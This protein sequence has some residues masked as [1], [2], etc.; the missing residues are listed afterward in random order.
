MKVK[1]CN[2]NEKTGFDGDRIFWKIYLK[3]RISYGGFL[4]YSMS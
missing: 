1:V 3:M 4:R 2:V